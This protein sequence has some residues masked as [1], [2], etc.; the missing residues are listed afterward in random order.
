MEATFFYFTQ[1]PIR[2]RKVG[3]FI[4]EIYY[5][6]K[7][8]L[9]G[10]NFRSPVVSTSGLATS[11]VAV[12]LRLLLLGILTST[13]SCSSSSSESDATNRFFAGRFLPH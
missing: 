3:I 13:A 1:I 4:D 9:P 8:L 5:L 11:L 12:L 2:I 10:S 6:A 7:T